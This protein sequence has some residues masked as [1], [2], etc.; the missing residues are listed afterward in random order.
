MGS[1]RVGHD[2]RDLAAAAAAGEHK[3]FY[4]LWLPTSGDSTFMIGIVLEQE[5]EQL[6]KTA[7]SGK[8]NHCTSG[9][10]KQTLWC[11]YPH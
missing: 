7:G 3:D 10:E 9:P 5:K 6:H 4:S 11:L 1:H 2:R 8:K